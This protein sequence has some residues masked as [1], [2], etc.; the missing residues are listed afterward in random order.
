MV[1]ELAAGRFYC[2]VDALAPAVGF[3]VL[4]A[5]RRTFQVGEVLEV[6]LPPARPPRTR[7]RI[8]GPGRLVDPTHVRLE[9][10]GMV[11]IEVQAETPGLGLGDVAWPW[12]LGQP[13]KVEAVR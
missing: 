5:D 8:H 2:A 9:A 1:Q 10:P 11:L 13:V 6:R 3:A 4:P 12:L 7:L